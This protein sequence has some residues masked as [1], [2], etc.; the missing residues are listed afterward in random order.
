MLPNG[1]VG[2]AYSQTLR[3]TGGAPSYSW[4]VIDGSLPPRLALDSSTGAI[5]GVPTTADVYRFTVQVVDS[6][7]A[8]ASKA[9][10]ITA[11]K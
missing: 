4:T 3:A 2:T 1:T 11:T 8:T 5:S 10:S 7:R 9:L 6:Q